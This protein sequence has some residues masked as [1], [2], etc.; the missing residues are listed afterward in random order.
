MRMPNDFS[1]LEKMIYSGRGITVGMTPEGSTVVGYTLTGRSR[2]SQAREL[3]YKNKTNTI[4]TNPTDMEV[5]KGGNAALLLY[6]AVVGVDCA[7]I[8]SNGIQTNLIYSALM[9]DR[10]FVLAGKMTAEGIMQYATGDDWMYNQADDSW[11]NTGSYEPDAPNNTPRIS[12]V[13]LEDNACMYI[14]RRKA[15]EDDIAERKFHSFRLEPGH[16][17]VITT[18]KGGNEKPLLPFEGEPLDVHIE[19][20]TAEDIAESLYA[21]IH[22]GQNPGDNYRVAAAVMLKRKDVPESSMAIINRSDRGE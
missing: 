21:A 16:G 20:S 22:G 12:A 5:L 18:Y 10:N 14:V 13:A 6:P 1:A 3:V 15:G 2:S 19:S 7:L 8:A 17:K 11:I 4:I 9:R